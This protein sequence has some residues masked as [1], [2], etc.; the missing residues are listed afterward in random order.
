MEKWFRFEIEVTN[1]NLMHMSI[2]NPQ[3]P[4]STLYLVTLNKDSFELIQ[5]QQNLVIEQFSLLPQHMTKLLDL[6]L[7]Q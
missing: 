3:D 7:S 5:Q 4:N 6:C 1:E 2:Y